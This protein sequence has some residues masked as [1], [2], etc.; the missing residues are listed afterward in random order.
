MTDSRD[1]IPLMEKL[2]KSQPWISS[3][4][5]M[6]K[7]DPV[8]ESQFYTSYRKDFLP[9]YIQ[10]SSRNADG[11]VSYKTVAINLPGASDT[12]MNRWKDNISA[13]LKLSPDSIYTSSRTLSMEI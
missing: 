10:R 8:L 12:L 3:V 7:N 9:Y 11:S 1:M 2:S 5:D 4:I 13:A 6:I